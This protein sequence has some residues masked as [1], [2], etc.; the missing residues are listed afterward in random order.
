[1]NGLIS[2]SIWWFRGCRLVGNLNLGTPTGPVDVE[3]EREAIYA[4]TRLVRRAALRSCRI[5]AG[6]RGVEEFCPCRCRSVLCL[7][8]A[9]SCSLQNGG[10]HRRALAGIALIG[11]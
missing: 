6:V 11:I 1:M 2:F 5:S 8:T 9:D 3:L 10:I 7:P 4:T